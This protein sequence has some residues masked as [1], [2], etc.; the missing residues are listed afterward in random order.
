LKE[1]KDQNETKKLDRNKK[2]K[3]EH[4]GDLLKVSISMPVL[5]LLMPWWFVGCHTVTFSGSR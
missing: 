1:E 5:V 4:K 2:V 3:E